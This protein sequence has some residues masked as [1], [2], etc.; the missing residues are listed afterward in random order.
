MRLLFVLSLLFFILFSQV[1]L[2]QAQQNYSGLVDSIEVFP[3][4]DTVIH[5]GDV[6]EFTARAYDV[7]GTYL[8][9]TTFTWSLADPNDSIGFFAG[10]DFTGT[11]VGSGNVKATAEGVTALSGSIT[12]VHGD[13][14]RMFLDLSTEQLAVQP[15]VSSAEIILYDSYDNF[16]T[17]YD[18]SLYPVTLIADS[19][20]FDPEVIDDN[21]YQVGGV[22][23]LIP[24]GI[25]YTGNTVISDVYAT[26]NGINS[27]A[28]TVSFNG[29]DILDVIDSEG[30]TIDEIYSGAQSTI[31]VTVQNNG[32]L[33]PESSAEVSVSY[34]M[35]GSGNTE[36]FT[37]HANGTVDTIPIMLPSHT[38]EVTEDV[39]EVHLAA[40][41]LIGGEI[42]TS[43]DTMELPVTIL[44][45]AKFNVIDN[46]LKPD[47][48][49]PGEEFDISFSVSIGSFSGDFDSTILTVELAESP[50]GEGIVV[51]REDAPIPGVFIFNTLLYWEV[52]CLVPSELGLTSGM[53]YLK[54]DY[55][56]YTGNLIY[57][58]END[59]PDSIYLLPEVNLNYVNGT[60]EPTVVYADDETSFSFELN[61]TNS[62]PINISPELSSFN[63]VGDGFSVSTSL[64]SSNTQLLTGSNILECEKVYIP[65]G[66]LGNELHADVE[67]LYSVV[68][69]DPTFTFASD[70]NNESVIVEELPSVKI[71]S[72]DMVA[73]NVPK[74]NIGQ[75]YQIVCRVAN[76]SDSDV[77]YLTLSM[78]SDGGSIFDP[79]YILLNIPANDTADAYFNL[80]AGNEVNSSELFTVDIIS[81]N[82]NILIPVNHV[83]MVQ[84][85]KPA[86]LKL[87]YM[88]LGSE[89]SIYTY[90]EEFQLGV[91]LENDG[92]ADFSTGRYL[93]TTGNVDFGLGDSISGEIGQEVNLFSLKAPSFDTV[94]TF[95]FELTEIPLD[96]NDLDPATI[97][98]TWLEFQVRIENLEAD[99]LVESETINP[100]LILPGR[101]LNLF[102]LNLV[103]YG[104]SQSTRIGL[105]E[106]NLFFTD[107]EDN[108]VQAS[109]FMIAG[110]TGFYENDVR[111][112]RTTTGD[113]RAQF[114]FD[115]FIIEPGQARTLYFEA[116]IKATGEKSFKLQL[117]Q[118]D[119][120]VLFVEGPHA[121]Q[122]PS[123]VTGV[124]DDIVFSEIYALKS[125][126][127]ESSF[128]I[129]DN[130]FNPDEVP[131]VFSYELNEA[132]AVELKIFTITGEEVY[133]EYFAK[134]SDKA[135]L[136]ENFF[137]WNGCNNKGDIV[138]NGVYIASI[139]ILSSGETAR[140]KVA[141]VR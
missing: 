47:S 115:E 25:K 4:G 76:L 79:E 13:L 104:I 89:T 61:L 31:F 134:G 117:D 122:S 50:G 112:T 49:Y 18:L 85:E 88:L 106:I 105:E 140:M 84:T 30:A 6:I 46:S 139:R 75:E 33:S 137:E 86:S 58:L 40:D 36:T 110:K 2:T 131:A 59:Y 70:F 24:A 78:V 8:P 100:N 97:D 52:D 80:I 43:V 27:Q 118:N 127:L 21:T 135:I 107:T 74:V 63:I 60:L 83:V 98:L 34:R 96:L 102:K 136:G 15:L 109:S 44:Q 111:I 87:T 55:R 95:R 39:L 12:V 123:I 1:A 129:R 10:A 72:V 51:I 53:Y 141:V 116:C 54:F 121:G 20:Q 19:G 11:R 114:L 65:E 23:R 124:E 71:I 82:I 125:K 17:D 69:D 68:A 45:G 3:A 90:G 108:P 35:D 5:S 128:V 93:L 57:T 94:V 130:P 126:S 26:S 56:L 119:I 101:E 29:Y 77:G 103:N 7:D 132:S 42:Y 41:F 67:I 14:D 91:G 38:L 120:D 73:P 37:G 28:V 138:R 92:D 66:Q 48:C 9:L 113:N 32:N 16:V 62:Y 81:N 22:V 64:V 133:S 99:L